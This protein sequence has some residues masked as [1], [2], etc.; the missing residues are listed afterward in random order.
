MKRKRKSATPRDDSPSVSFNKA[1]AVATKRLDKALAERQTMLDRLSA[2]NAEIPALQGTIGALRRQLEPDSVTFRNSNSGLETKPGTG[3]VVV[4]GIP[5]EVLATLPPTDLTG[6]RSEPAPQPPQ[7]ANAKP[8]PTFTP[9]F[10]QD[11]Y[12]QRTEQ[13]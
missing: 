4:P 3:E 9:S 8:D 1:L 11:F 12:K 7:P 5:P 13:Q 6:M 10:M 2:L